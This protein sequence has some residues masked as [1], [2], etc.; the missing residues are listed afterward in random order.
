M[1][2][3]NFFPCLAF[4]ALSLSALSACSNG[5][6]TFT[7]R[8]VNYDDTLLYEEVQVAKGS[9]VAYPGNRP[10]RF[11]DNKSYYTFSG[12]DQE[13][14]PVEKDVT[15][16]ATFEAHPLTLVPENP[17]SYIDELPQNTEDGS[18]LHAFCWK[19]TDIMA[20]LPYIRDAGYKSVQ[21]SPVQT[22]KSNGSSWWAYYQPLSFSIAESSPLGT[23]EELTELCSAAEMFGIS[24]IVDVVFNHMA[25]V[26]SK[27]VEADGTPSVSPKVAEYEPE[28]Y[29]HRNDATDPTFHHYKSTEVK[30]SGNDTQYYPELPDLNT[31]N[32]LVQKRAYEFLEECIDVGVDGFRFDAAKHIE[33][34]DDPNYPSDF[35]TNTLGKAKQYYKN[36][37]GN[38]LYAYGEILGSP[39]SRK[40]DVYTKIMDVNDDSYGF[41]INSAVS[42]QS[43]LEAASTPYKVEDSNAVIGWLDTHDTYVTDKNPWSNNFLSQSWAILASRK[44]YRGLYFARP[45]SGSAPSIGIIGD[46]FF[47]NERLGAVNRFHNRFVGASEEQSS[48]GTIY[49]NER[50]GDEDKGAVVVNTGSE[51]KIIVEFSKLGTDVYYDQ[52]TGKAVTVRNG[53]ATIELASS[54]IAVL[55]RSKNGP[56]P[57]LDIDNHG[58][59][60]VDEMTVNVSFENAKDM[61]YSINESE[62]LPVPADG[63][64]TFT[65]EQAIDDDIDLTIEYTGQYLDY[66]VSQTFHYKSASLIDGYFN[67][68]NVDPEHISDYEIYMW[69]WKAGENGKWSK[70]YAIQDGIILVDTDAL[71]IEGM[72]FGRFEKDYVITNLNEWDNNVLKQTTDITGAVL[73]QGYYDGSAF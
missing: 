37:T 21:T 69:S 25:N 63:K 55:T 67:I 50:Y 11:D 49:V 32:A 40:I 3:H 6:S 48:D 53:H 72:V 13:L 73:A 51:R 58:G 38:D 29:A 4:A 10:A 23:K 17:V 70:D 1:K 39:V 5:P 66:T 71:G 33:T 62:P 46:Y 64:I 68:L 18:I 65:A 28:I 16:K 8:F 57:T 30:G 27:T 34:P 26:D 43:A 52:M 22:P 7:V 42:K 15:Y 54:G 59:L 41:R 61:V 20:E 56:L 44:D 2:K 45:D 31:G 12:W 14:A 35:W 60:F 36:K 24:I 9:T 19:F 47:K